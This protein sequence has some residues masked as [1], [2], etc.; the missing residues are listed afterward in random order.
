MDITNNSNNDNNTDHTDEE[1]LG[2]LPAGEE[3]E[4]ADIDDHGKL[5]HLNAVD[6]SDLTLN[7]LYVM[8]RLMRPWASDELGR[9]MTSAGVYPQVPGLSVRG[10]RKAINELMEAKLI[11]MVASF[12]PAEGLGK[13][14]TVL[15]F[16]LLMVADDYGRVHLD[17]DVF[18]VH[19]ERHAVAL[20]AREDRLDTGDRND[21]LERTTRESCF[22]TDELIAE[23]QVAYRLM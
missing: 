7:Q 10:T 12:D 4:S 9:F 14:E 3:I 8:I 23:H 16:F 11:R 20:L 13:A 2:N 15:W 5:L 18:I 21:H 17:A 6:F 1:P 22:E 19:R